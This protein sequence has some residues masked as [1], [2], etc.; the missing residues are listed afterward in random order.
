[1]T[2]NTWMLSLCALAVTLAPEAMAQRRNSPLQNIY[3]FQPMPLEELDGRI[4][5]LTE[6]AAPLRNIYDITNR[7]LMSGAAANRPWEG[8][9]WPLIQGQIANIWQNKGLFHALDYLSWKENYSDFKK[10]KANLLPLGIDMDEKQLARLAPSEKYDLLLGDTNYDLTNR[11]WSF[12]ETWG[13]QKINGF[14]TKIDM[15]PGYRLPKANT[16]MAMWEGICHGWALAAGGYPE[17]VKTVHVTLPNGKR[18]PFYPTDIKALI[19]LSFANSVVQNETL[20]EGFR[21]NNK[22]PRQDEYGRYIDQLPAR[23]EIGIL[24]RC[25]DVHPAVWHLAVVNLMGVQ[26]R[27]FVVEVDANAKVN[28]H[29]LA[30]YSFEYYNPQSGRSGNLEK[31]MVPV[32]KYRRDPYLGSRH[33]D[34]RYIVGVDMR[35]KYVDWVSPDDAKDDDMDS[36]G[37][38]KK[39]DFLYDLELDAYGNIIGGQWRVNHVVEY[40]TRD[41]RASTNQPDFFWALPKDYKKHF[42]GLP[43]LPAWRVDSSRPAPQEW[44]NAAL[45]AHSYMFQETAEF[46]FNTTCPVINGK[47]VI[48]VP[49]EFKHPKPQPLLNVVNQLVELSR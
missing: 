9:F 19:S 49:C 21:C 45:G 29:P 28:N 5:R 36:D 42:K 26:K 44:K 8:S 20:I 37:H 47:K 13:N 12:V 3:P 41:S 15:P 23:D 7:G 48:R 40:I 39:K 25:A 10:R 38:I 24:P 31:V 22:N 27:S 43:T 30:A 14:L 33:P 2:K 32:E 17:P 35:M 46:G 34:T 18:M 4:K 11:I 6:E 16:R 1:M